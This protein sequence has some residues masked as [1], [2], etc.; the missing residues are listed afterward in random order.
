MKH[1]TCTDP[2]HGDNIEMHSCCDTYGTWASQQTAHEDEAVSWL[3]A[4]RKFG[5]GMAGIE[6]ANKMFPEG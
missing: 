5:G 2:Q 3:L 4:V 1:T 6:A